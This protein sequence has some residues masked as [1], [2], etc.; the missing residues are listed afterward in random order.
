M[1]TPTPR[2]DAYTE[3][4]RAAI[5]ALEERFGIEL[6]SIEHHEIALRELAAAR[7]ELAQERERADKLQRMKEDT[8]LSWKR[9][10]DVEAANHLATKDR[11]ERAEAQA[12][13][14]ARDAERYR[15]LRTVRSATDW[16][17]VVQ[18]ISHTPFG[19]PFPV[20]L[21]GDDLDRQLDAAIAEGK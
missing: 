7:E 18:K 6:V 10:Y 15:L 19:S 1:T 9:L 14:N 3:E 21:W 20:Q 2:T 11:A 17:F 16:R 5:D 12:E 13:K 8:K 4:C